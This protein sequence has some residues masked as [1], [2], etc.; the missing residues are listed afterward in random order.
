MCNEFKDGVMQTQCTDK[1]L[2]IATIA[3]FVATE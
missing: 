1:I 3:R 2:M